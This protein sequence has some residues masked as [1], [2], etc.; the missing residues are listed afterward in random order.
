MLCQSRRPSALTDSPNNTNSEHSQ[1]TQL[2]NSLVRLSGEVETSIVSVE[3]VLEYTQL[4]SEAPD[5]IYHRRPAISWPAQGAVRFVD[6]STR[7]RPGLDLVLRKIDF[8]IKPGEK[9][10]VVGRTGAGK[11]SLAL[12]LFRIIEPAGGSIRI[13]G[14]DISTIGL[15]DLRGRLGVIPQ[16]AVLFEGTIRG[17]LDPGQLHDDTELWAALGI[18]CPPPFVKHCRLALTTGVDHARLREHVAKM[19]GG[20]DAKVYQG[21]R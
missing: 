17:N 20:L 9:I 21:G 2:F 15:L 4:P 8:E 6:Y 16:D 12:S 13:D 7:Y 18:S 10:G 11:S 3:R 14:L 19:A 5:V 1:T